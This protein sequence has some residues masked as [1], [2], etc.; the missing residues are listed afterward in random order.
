LLVPAA[1]APTAAEAQVRVQVRVTRPTARIVIIRRPA[2]VLIAQVVPPPPPPAQPP[3]VIIQE[4]PPPPPPP[5]Q[6]APPPPPELP[7]AQPQWQQPR[8]QRPP[9]DIYAGRFGFR[10][11]IGGMI[12][13]RVQMGGF[14]AAFRF[15]PIGALALDFGVGFYG[16]S[17]YNNQPRL[18]IPVTVDSIFFLNPRRRVQFYLLAGVGVSRA[19]AGFDAAGLGGR[20]FTYLGGEVGAGLEFRLGRHIALNLDVRPF[21]RGRI[22]SDPRPEFVSSTGQTTDVSAGVRGT[23]GGTIYF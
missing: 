18:E 2:P 15:R 4:A 3:V 8:P 10:P 6:V 5:A 7:P 17:D 19:Y 11:Q 9:Q 1:I 16:G 14:T 23:F 20:D 21:L 22:D 13:D 12:N